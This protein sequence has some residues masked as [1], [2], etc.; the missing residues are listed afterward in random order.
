M[1]KHAQGLLGA[2]LDRIQV[3]EPEFSSQDNTD[4]NKLCQRG[5]QGPSS[6]PAISHSIVVVAFMFI[7][8]LLVFVFG[9]DCVFDFDFGLMKQWGTT[10]FRESATAGNSSNSTQTNDPVATATFALV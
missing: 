6:S 5:S 1:Q 8:V 7:P 2:A 9:S 4:V 10:G 3:P